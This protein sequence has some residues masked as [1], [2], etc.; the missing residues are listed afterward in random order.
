MNQNEIMREYSIRYGDKNGSISFDQLD[1]LV[2]LL[3]NSKRDNAIDDLP[4]TGHHKCH[5]M[6]DNLYAEKQMIRWHIHDA[7]K[8][9]SDMVYLPEGVCPYC[10][11]NLNV[12]D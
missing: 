2:D 3:K 1:G 12:I 9:H 8:R 4:L 11:D 7:N 6:P 10:L 5:K